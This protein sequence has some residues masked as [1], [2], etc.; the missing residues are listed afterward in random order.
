MAEID[1]FVEN[2]SAS[3]YA[4]SNCL[5][6]LS[7]SVVYCDVV[8]PFCLLFKHFGFYY[9]GGF[10][11]YVS[12]A[13]RRT[14]FPAACVAAMGG[15]QRSWAILSSFVGSGTGFGIFILIVFI[16]FKMSISGKE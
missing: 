15:L 7:I 1:S 11:F 14:E 2:F 5:R 9:V 12:L 4:A 6:K 3:I 16:I 8:F 13:G 10:Y